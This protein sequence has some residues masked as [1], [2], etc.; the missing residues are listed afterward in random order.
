[1]H[2]LH[3]TTTVLRLYL[4]SFEARLCMRILQLF[5]GLTLSNAENNREG[6]SSN[7]YIIHVSG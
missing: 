1:M 7:G 3:A 2:P 5:R 6:H 4:H